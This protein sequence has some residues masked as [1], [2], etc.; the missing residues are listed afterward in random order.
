[1]I[2]M[3]MKKI[4]LIEDNTDVRETTADI[5]ELAHYEVF[6]AESGKEGIEKAV[7]FQPDLIICDIMMP[8]LDGYAVLHILSKKPET[9]SIPFIFLTAK[10]EKADLRKGMNLGAD[11]Y[12]TKPFEEME[13]LHAVESRLQKNELLKKEF[14]KGISG[15][16]EFY[17]EASEFRELK[18][19]SKKRKVKAFPKKA[20]IY[21][22]GSSALVLYFVHTG[23][24]KTYKTSKEGK[25]FITGLFSAGDFFGYMPLLGKTEIYSETAVAMEDTELCLIPQQDFYKLLYSNRNVA[26]K[27]IKM[28]SN[29]LMERE[30]QLLQVAYHSVRQRVAEALLQLSKTA[31][32]TEEKHPVVIITRE[33]L[34]GFVG[35]VKET[36]VRTLSD[37]KEEGL[38]TLD[39][40]KIVIMDRERLAKVNA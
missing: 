35:T 33:D 11:D 15:L 36:I 13:L 39:R 37:F 26:R 23:R 31:S 7:Q 10:S 38:I 22:E 29:N 14:S 27:F 1:M 5:L 40:K 12:L 4:V 28:L 34:A 21:L 3:E 30:T 6:T 25:E 2:R 8:G 19:L 9:A 24:V 17:H 32:N 20:T 18:D 16:D